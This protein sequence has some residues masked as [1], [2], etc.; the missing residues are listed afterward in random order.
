MGES[1]RCHFSYDKEP[2]N[3]FGEISSQG[4]GSPELYYLMVVNSIMTR[5]EIIVLSMIFKQD[6]PMVTQPQTNGQAE[7]T[8]K[9]ILG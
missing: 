4:L 3:S 7:S 8:K 9:Q 5:L 6:S 2:K 1:W